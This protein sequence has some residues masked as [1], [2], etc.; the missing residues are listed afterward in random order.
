MSE[1]VDAVEVDFKWQL[2]TDV[3]DECIPLI[4][5]GGDVMASAET[6]SGKTAA[7]A[8]PIVQLCA[9]AREREEEAMLLRR[10]QQ[11]QQKKK[12]GGGQHPGRRADGAEEEKNPPPPVRRCCCWRMSP[13]D[14]DRSLAMKSD[15]L[16]AQCRDD[17]GG[18][19]F[20]GCRSTLGVAVPLL[21]DRRGGNGG[22]STPPPPPLLL[23]YACR[24]VD[25]GIVRIG[26][27]S[28]DASRDLGSDA[29]GWGYGSTG[30]KVHAKRYLP[31][32]GETAGG[33]TTGGSVGASRGSG[34]D[35]DNNNSRN[36][37]RGA[38][39]KGDV[40]GCHLRLVGAGE[41]VTGGDDCG[42]GGGDDDDVSDGKDGGDGGEENEKKNPVVAVLS[43]TKN[44]AELGDAFEIRK[45]ELQTSDTGGAA[46][47]LFPTVCLKN[48]ECV[49]QFDGGDKEASASATFPSSSTNSKYQWLSSLSAGGKN[50]GSATTASSGNGDS[51]VAVVNN[52]RD[53][54]SFAT[55]DDGD[56]R[57]PLAIVIEPTRDLA[58]QTFRVFDELSARISD[59]PTAAH[60]PVRSVLLVG[61]ISPKKALKELESNNVDILVGTPPIIASYMRKGSIGATRCRHFV[62]DEADELVSSD[63]VK[64]IKTIYGRISAAN[65]N[66]SR[67]ERLQV[68]FFSATLESEEVR[69]LAGSICHR[70]LW[71]KLRSTMPDTVHHCFV[72]IDP[73]DFMGDQD[74]LKTDAVHRGGKLDNAVSLDGLDEDEVNSEKVKQL[75]M[76]AVLEVLE[77]FSMDQVLIFMRTN[78]DCDLMESFLRSQ[79]A[80][81]TSAMVDKYSCRVLAGM[82]SMQERQKSLEDFK[83]GEARILICTDVAA[84]G[85]K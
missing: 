57:G 72:C 60:P 82:R 74:F 75:K 41:G 5:G 62:L 28:A 34:S 40:I 64:N 7:F 26:W 58:E 83:S 63:S 13:L 55:L 84:R 51:S 68:C 31:Y 69:E 81:G 12:Q 50:D 17:S 25:D 70:P 65:E 1:L 39:G 10:G 46:A 38:F 2:P 19:A 6:G 54:I 35:E 11:Q 37:R 43:Y 23:S 76:R 9:E 4:L 36:G 44:G 85:S 27:S 61:G 56:R 45:R 78:L 67:F 30:V 66:K 20:A 42:G 79:S 15:G 3:Q 53:S 18:A 29:E 14:R 47:A 59:S 8:I 24:V 32:G 80:G 16:R 52:P 33:E 77:K 73:K 48:A 49:L 71:I 22:S 21:P